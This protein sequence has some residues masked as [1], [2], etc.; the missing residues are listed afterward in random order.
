MGKKEDFEEGTRK[1]EE[2]I[3]EIDSKPSSPSSGS[4]MDYPDRCCP[5]EYIR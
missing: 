2:M 4:G 3:K 5:H 1:V